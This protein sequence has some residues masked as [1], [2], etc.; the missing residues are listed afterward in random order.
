MTATFDTPATEHG[1]EV[2]IPLNRL[3][4]S[5][6]NARKTPHRPEDIETMAASIHAKGIIQP[7]VVEPDLD[8]QGQPTGDYLVTIGEGRRLAQLLRVKRKQIK[9]TEP[10]TDAFL[11]ASIDKETF[12]HRKAGL[13]L[14]KRGIL[15]ALEDPQI[16]TERAQLLKKLELGNTAYLRFDSEIAAEKR[17]AVQTIMSNLIVDGKSLGFAL[18]FPFDEVAKQRIVLCGA[19]FR[20]EPRSGVTLFVSEC[21]RVPRRSKKFGIENFCEEFEDQ[22]PKSKP[23]V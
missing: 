17:D 15:D 6:K 16:G 12:E 8:E 13:F 10:I 3:K 23:T 22:M 20:A 18:R 1:T 19:P 14:E 5:E 11:D 4:K 21:G 2:Y 9:K 7:P